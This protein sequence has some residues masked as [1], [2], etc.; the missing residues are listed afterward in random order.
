M[1][2]TWRKGLRLFGAGPLRGTGGVR[3]LD[4]ELP[5]SKRLRVEDDLGLALGKVSERIK[6]IIQNFLSISFYLLYALIL[7]SLRLN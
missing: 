2:H 5:L 4:L 6:T 3:R 7:K 1:I